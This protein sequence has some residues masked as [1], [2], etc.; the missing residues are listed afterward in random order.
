MPY[1]GDMRFLHIF[2]LG[3]LLM[4]SFSPV[5]ASA[6]NA[7]F[8]GPIISPACQCEGS[9][10]DW[11]CVLD[12]VQR[13]INLG[14]SL[15]T[16]FAV[17]A[18]AY[19]GA[20]WIFSSVNPANREKGR[21]M[22]LNIVIGYLVLL[23]AW[24]FIDFIM[25]TIYNPDVQVSSSKQLGPWNSILAAG[26]DSYCIS[27]KSPTP[28]QPTQTTPTTPGGI[29]TVPNPT[30]PNPTDG[31]VRERLLAAG[32]RVNKSECPTGTP[33]QD[34]SGGC[35]SVE[36]LKESTITLAIQIARAC[37]DCNIILTGGSELGHSTNGTRTHGNGYKIDLDHP[38]SQLDALIQGMTKVDSINGDTPTK[39]NTYKD[40]CG[41]LYV[42]EPTHWDI[43]ASQSC[44]D[45]NQK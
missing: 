29:G 36:G 42:K 8:F 17:L 31:T 40:G 27:D 23:C 18:I 34:V 19:A 44:S 35:T 10:P 15:G 20:L 21:T 16:V 24:I 33:Y 45:F 13:V 11:G 9:A 2:A 14:I 28:I 12:S 3:L 5:D 26:E 30:T 4:V 41:N 37:G 7:D 6:A 25:K 32:I 22:L 39:Y 38:N 1:T 43:Y